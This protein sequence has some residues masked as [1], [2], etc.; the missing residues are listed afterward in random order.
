VCLDLL[1]L[2]HPEYCLRQSPIRPSSPVPEHKYLPQFTSDTA[3]TV[4]SGHVSARHKL[5][6][7]V[8]LHRTAL[9]CAACCTVFKCQLPGLTPGI[10]R[11]LQLH[12]KHHHTQF[13]D[14]DLLDGPSLHLKSRFSA[15]Q[16][17]KEK[18]LRPEGLLH[19]LPS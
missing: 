16:G 6:P 11:L 18:S 3:V 4:S 5:A 1:A 14:Y 9:Y 2:W 15:S 13:A 8:A 19:H 7:A 17:K 12:R 10:I